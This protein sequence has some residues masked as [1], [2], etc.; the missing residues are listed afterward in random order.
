MPYTLCLPPF[1]QLWGSDFPVY[2]PGWLA[3]LLINA[4]Y[5]FINN[6]CSATRVMHAVSTSCGADCVYQI[7]HKR[8]L[9]LDVWPGNLIDNRLQS[10]QPMSGVAVTAVMVDCYAYC[11]E[12][13]PPQQCGPH[14]PFFGKSAMRTRWNAG[15]AHH[16]SGR[17]R[18]KSRSENHTQTNTR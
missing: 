15:T 8:F 13:P 4:D 11:V 12:T 3:L 5:Y 10:T 16:K 18:D 9:P 1:C 14:L 7:Q 17:C 6:G 2:S